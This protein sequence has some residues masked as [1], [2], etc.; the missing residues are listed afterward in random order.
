M[1][2]AK[3][4]IVFIFLLAFAVCV[5]SQSVQFSNELKSYEFYGKGKLKP[6]KLLI[7]K[8]G[9]WESIFGKNC[10][11]S[12]DLNKDW[13]ISFYSVDVK[14]PKIVTENKIERKFFLKPQY[15]NILWSIE[16]MPKK[17][18]SFKNFRFPKAF[19]KSD[20]FI[21]EINWSFDVY[22]D[23]NGLSYWIL[24]ENVRDYQKGDLYRI[25]YEVPNKLDS[26]IYT[27]EEPKTKSK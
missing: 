17:R 13:R 20:G 14:S 10:S 18:I 15:D 21:S 26:E 4:F 25:E 11:A 5:S 24:A 27:L 6:L 1:K 2:L 8:L 16:L 3:I 23:S 7:S 9:D 12:C 22:Q 19:E